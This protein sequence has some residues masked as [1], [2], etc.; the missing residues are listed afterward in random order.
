MPR[1]VQGDLGPTKARERMAMPAI[2]LMALAT[3]PTFF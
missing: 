3:E 1:Y 2:I